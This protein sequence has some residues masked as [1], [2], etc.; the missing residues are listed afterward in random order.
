VCQNRRNSWAK[1]RFATEKI[2]QDVWTLT[3]VD[4]IDLKVQAGHF[5]GFLGPN[6]AGKIHDNQDA[7]GTAGAD[8][9]A[10]GIAWDSIS[11]AS[12][13]GEAPDRRGPE[14]MGVV[15]AINGA[16]YLRFVGEMY[17]LDRATTEKRAEDCW[18]S[19]NW[20][21]GRRR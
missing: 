1:S 11:K 19:C 8:V 7:D 17:G 9:G 15:R 13:G 21:I 10:H 18:N 4:A 5:F 20:P 3:A 14:G 2:D 6:G 16:E 12:R